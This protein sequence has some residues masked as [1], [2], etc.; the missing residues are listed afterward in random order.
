MFAVFTS[1]WGFLNFIDP[2]GTDRQ[3]D[4]QYQ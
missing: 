4:E 2:Y 3:R 1:V